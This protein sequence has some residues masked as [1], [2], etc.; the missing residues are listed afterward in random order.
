MKKQLRL[1]Q[2]IIVSTLLITSQ[3]YADVTINTV[4]VDRDTQTAVDGNVT[5]ATTGQLWMNAAFPNGGTAVLVN[6]GSQIIT[7]DANNTV[8]V[9]CVLGSAICTT[10]AGTSGINIVPAGSSASI[11]VG[12]NTRITAA[13]DGIIVDGPSASIQN[14]GTITG[15]GGSAINITLNGLSTG[16]QNYTGGTLTGTLTP[17]ISVNGQNANISNAGTITTTGALV[18]AIQLNQNFSGLSNTTG[19][20]IQTL[21]GSG[22][23]L[24]AGTPLTGN[25]LN[26]GTITTAT[27]NGINLQQALNGS[28]F[29]TNIIN[30][31]G[32]AGN[33]IR[34]GS[35][36]TNL[37]NSGTITATAGSFPIN[38]VANVTGTIS[39]SGTIQSNNTRA[40]TL[41]GNIT[42]LS[43]TGTISVTNNAGLPAIGVTVANV[44]V[45][46]GIG[47]TGTITNVL[48]GTAIDLSL[49]RNIVLTQAAGTI[50]GN[51]LLAR[52]GGNI[53]TQ[54]G[55]TITGNVTANSANQN[56]LTLSGGTLNGTLQLGSAAGGD[57]VN[58]SGTTVTTILGGAG[59]T[60]GTINQSGGQFTTLTATL[61]TYNVSGP[62][63]WTAA[64]TNITVDTINL[65]NPATVTNNSTNV[66]TRLLTLAAGSSLTNNRALV[67]GAGGI[68]NNGTFYANAN[69]TTANNL[70]NGGSYSVQNNSVTT[71]GGTTT[72]TGLI[73]V[74]RDTANFITNI[75]T[76]TAPGTYAPEIYA[77]GNNGNIQVTTTANLGVNSFVAPYYNSGIYL[78]SGSTFDVLTAGAGL[79]TDNSTLVQPNSATLYFVKSNVANTIIRLTAQHRPFATSVQGQPATAVG[80]ELDAIARA[81]TTDPA[82]LILLGQLDTLSSGAALQT[83]LESLTPTINYAL[84][85][86]SKVSIDSVFSSILYRVEKMKNL[87]PMG[88]EEY[89][90]RQPNTIYRGYVGQNYGDGCCGN[91][92]DVPTND[93]GVWIGA[94][95]SLLNQKKFRNF[96]GYKGDSVGYAI[97]S[98]WG[99]PDYAVAGLALSYTNTHTVGNNMAANVVDIQ[100]VQGTAYTW[101]EPMDSVFIDAMYGFA[102]HRYYSRRNIGVGTFS[103]AAFGEKFY[104]TQYAVQTDLGYAFTYDYLVVAPVGRFKYGYLAVD[105]YTET[106]AAGVGLSVENKSLKE[107]VGGVGIQLLGH[108][109]FAQAQYVPELSA[110]I[111]YDFCA[112]GQETSSNFL[113]G[114][115]FF[116]TEGPNPSHTSYL[117]GL[118]VTAYTYD[119]YSFQLRYNLQIGDRYHFYANSGFMELRGE[120][121]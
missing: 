103:T 77:P 24:T 89:T 81:G 72:N 78:P 68:L 19:G 80:A 40:I 11:V 51:V 87:K 120:W 101:I 73:S 116:P 56:I 33:G 26:S 52:Q 25:I 86:G 75:F 95:G 20:V 14:S 32:V 63:T 9:N 112:D 37:T 22:I 29:N 105:S 57:T 10:P 74:A 94:Y 31:T 92:N 23:D 7:L 59:S 67:V 79:L 93:V 35:G 21:G 62:I 38:V 3:V 66:N 107:L 113:G 45:A 69:V 88:A 114:G 76:Q 1:S 115:G 65:L 4:N 102:Q 28:I 109:T 2:T 121:G 41:G 106:G 17:T 110:M 55:G 71:I 34:I 97:G 99:N 6:S 39:N 5:I 44:D 118:G 82:L 90:I 104:G 27:G 85:Q 83:A 46:G 119:N 8:A 50:N 15:N 60:T 108:K 100:S 61:G 49:G 13:T 84:V 43:N 53:F 47:N 12:A 48:N 91:E 58:L 18:D 16:V 42:Q 36:F 54:S 70:T 30:V 64:P 111:L 117:Y 98:D 96:T